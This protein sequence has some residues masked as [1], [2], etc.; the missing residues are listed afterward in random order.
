MLKL[1]EKLKKLHEI[2][3]LDFMKMFKGNNIGFSI[4]V[5]IQDIKVIASNDFDLDSFEEKY[6]IV[7]VN[8]P[9]EKEL[10]FEKNY[11]NLAVYEVENV[12]F[13]CNL[14]IK[15]E[16]VMAICINEEIMYLSNLDKAS[17]EFL[18]NKIGIDQIDKKTSL[19][20]SY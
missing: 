15:Y 9:E 20:I 16:N 7:E 18:K 2:H 6:L 4:I 8:N 3:V 17:N 1:I 10:L 19:K 11:F 14:I 5:K 13:D 12:K